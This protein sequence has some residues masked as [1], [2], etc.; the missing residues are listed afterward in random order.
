LVRDIVP[1]L[2]PSLEGWNEVIA[3]RR[4]CGLLPSPEPKAAEVINRTLLARA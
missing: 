3:L 4:E 2:K 1:G